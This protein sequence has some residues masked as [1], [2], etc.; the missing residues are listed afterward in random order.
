MHR[1]G[2]SLTASIL[3]AA[4]LHVG[5]QLMAAAA[6]NPKG[7]YED[8]EFYNLHQRMLAGAGLSMDGFTCQESIDVPISS[9]VEAMELV[10][11]RRAGNR[12]WGWKD[13]RTTLFLEF[14]AELLPEARWL[15]VIRPPEQ[16]I[17]SLFRRGDTAF[18][19]NPPYAIDV[20]VSYSRR[21]LNFVRRHA[22]RV[23]VV[24]LATVVADPASV[25]HRVSQLLGCELT[26]P[27]SPYE[28][29]LLA[30]DQ[31]VHREA[32]IR[33]ARPDAY[34]LYEEL[35]RCGPH[36][37]SASTAIAFPPTA[38]VEAGIIEWARGCRERAGYAGML[39][40]EIATRR[41]LEHTV[42][43]LEATV[44]AHVA[45]EEER[46]V[47]V[48]QAH[49]E[50]ERERARNRQRE[51]LMAG[52]EA[53]VAQ[54]SNDLARA[55]VLRS[56]LEQQAAALR[57]ENENHRAEHGRLQGLVAD[58]IRAREKA[59]QAWAERLEAADAEHARAV[60]MLEDALDEERSL[61]ETL[62]DDR[63]AETEASADDDRA[64]MEAERE[65]L[66]AQLEAERMIFESLRLDMTGRIEA[67][68][69]AGTA[70]PRTL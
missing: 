45:E 59:E 26:V 6:G 53:S 56:T 44:A 68:L 61:V 17:D 13:P 5:D 47:A 1:S 32:L 29:G 31:T 28:P 25:V 66:I 42:R 10:R 38:S 27:A 2:T 7:H 37:Q 3:A 35:C 49:A 18:V 33:E 15:F 65:G 8:L 22:D 19:V 23:A 24:D 55:Q 46:I 63:I 57:S 58:A 60:A 9:R 20:W 62:R 41:S 11:R 34:A 30:T 50:L 64:A 43:D 51:T 70:G 16:V 12:P 4:G 52:L 39:E 69:T 40:R 48:T 54:L 21:I 14:W 36:T 67:A